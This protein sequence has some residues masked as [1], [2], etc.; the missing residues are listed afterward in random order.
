MSEELRL[1]FRLTSS[2][3]SPSLPGKPPRPLVP[4]KTEKNK[5]GLK[6]TQLWGNKQLTPK[7]PT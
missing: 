4:W 5:Q 3:G 6:V 1:D 7:D 2:P